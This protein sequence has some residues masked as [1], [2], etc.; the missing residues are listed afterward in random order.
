MENFEA[1]AHANPT[2]ADEMM[3]KLIEVTGMTDRAVLCKA[4]DQSKKSDANHEFNVTCAI[5]WILQMSE[6]PVPSNADH[7]RTRRKTPVQTT[8]FVNP[9]APAAANPVNNQGFPPMQP[10]NSPTNSGQQQQQ[11]LQQQP[12]SNVVG[13]NSNVLRSN[14]MPLVDLTDPSNDSNNKDDDADLEKAI[15]LSLQDVK[16][17]EGSNFGVTQEEQDVSR[18]LEA[19]LLENQFG[20]KRVRGIDYVDPLNPHDR[21]RNGM[22]TKSQL[23]TFLVS[24]APNFFCSGPW[25]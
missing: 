15:Q 25:A 11:H 14:S 5:E 12:Q 23:C 17:S 18:A 4:L 22:V 9:G 3:A 16:R 1:F 24:L 13:G 6:R 21:K 19:S 8:Q 10:P 7:Q 20:G 2:K